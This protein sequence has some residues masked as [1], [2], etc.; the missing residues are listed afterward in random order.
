MELV[1][2]SSRTKLSEVCAQAGAAPGPG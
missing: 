2:T 1:L